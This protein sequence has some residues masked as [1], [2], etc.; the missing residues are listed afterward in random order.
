MKKLI[1]GI[2]ALVSVTA[3]AG[4]CQNTAMEVMK[5]VTTSI[6][7]KG[8]LCKL[9]VNEYASTGISLGTVSASGSSFDAATDTKYALRFVIENGKCIPDSVTRL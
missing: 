8:G 5:G 3:Q 2:L 9:D 1:I 4:V 6:V 7:G